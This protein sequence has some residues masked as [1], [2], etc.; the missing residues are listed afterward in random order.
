MEDVGIFY[1]H[2][3]HFTAFCYILRTF[4]I[5]RGNLV[6]FFPFCYFVQRKIWQPWHE[7]ERKSQYLQHGRNDPRI[8]STKEDSP[9]IAL[10]PRPDPFDNFRIVVVGRLLG[11]RLHGPVVVNGVVS[12]DPA[13]DCS[14]AISDGLGFVGELASPLKGRLHEQ[15]KSVRLGLSVQI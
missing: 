5:V 6:Y 7:G 14:F 4:G 11:G 13:G 2:L 8:F 3:V 12:N 10:S 1:R 15:P 9:A